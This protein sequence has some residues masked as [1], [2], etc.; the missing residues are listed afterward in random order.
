MRFEEILILILLLCIVGVIVLF[1]TGYLKTG[2]VGGEEEYLVRY[3]DKESGNLST[4]PATRL[5]NGS[6][7]TLS[8]RTLGAAERVDVLRTISAGAC[9][10]DCCP[11]DGGDPCIEPE[12]KERYLCSDNRMVA[13]RGECEDDCDG[14]AVS[15]IFVCANGV[16]VEDPQQCGGVAEILYY[17]NDGSVATTESGCGCSSNVAVACIPAVAEIKYKC[18][19]GSIVISA[20]DCGGRDVKVYY[21]CSDGRKVKQE[22]DCSA[23][24]PPAYPVTALAN[25]PQGSVRIVYECWNGAI[26]RNK[27]DCP[28]Y[29]DRNCNCPEYERPVCGIDGRTYR[30]RCYLSCAGVEFAGEGE[31]E[32]YS[33]IEQG[34]ECTPLRLTTAVANLSYCCPGLECL[35]SAATTATLTHAV[36]PQGY[37]CQE[38]G[39]CADVDE[40]CRTDDDCC[41]GFSCNPNTGLCEEG[42]GPVGKACKLNESCCSG[43]C[44][45]YTD[46]CD[47][48]SSCVE[49]GGACRVVTA[50]AAIEQPCCPGLVCNQ[51]YGYCEQPSSCS[52]VG[53]SCK[54][55][56]ECCTGYC[57]P[58]T[59]KCDDRP[60]CFENYYPC[61]KDSECCSDY[62]NPNEK[63]CR[64]VPSCN[65]D[66]EN[67]VR[68]YDCEF[69]YDKGVCECKREACESQRCDGD[70]C[71]EIEVCPSQYCA[72]G[73]LY[74]G[75]TESVVA[76]G[77]VCQSQTPCQSKRCNTAGTA[78]G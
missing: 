68:E 10:C 76:A 12:P 44:N 62:C 66:C 32:I 73:I 9:Q 56:S 37:L 58:V 53:T 60:A 14:R 15:K 2:P 51:Q 50:A 4:E 1:A 70:E 45:P 78:C 61:S 25:I 3:Y 55:G 28:L 54:L 29:C 24:C 33:C 49:E 35:P 8:G 71:A 13:N 5:E 17:C 26:V 20:N 77:C 63:E 40:K 36:A 22:A 42:C 48:I 59:N 34:E 65:D 18:T 16:E 19:D 43:Y 64:R 39:T 75:C 52:E 41:Q 21:I 38:V 72:D 30:N 31:C 27:A 74:S 7:R 6:Y 69:N 67:G 46:R 11:D 57:D 23:D 47:E